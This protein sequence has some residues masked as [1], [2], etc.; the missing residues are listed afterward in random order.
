MTNEELDE[1]RM[2]ESMRRTLERG[3]SPHD[4][5]GFSEFAGRTAARL[6]R[7]GWLPTDPILNRA[8]DIVAK[9]FTDAGE[10]VSAEGARKGMFDD[11]PIMRA[12][13]AALQTAKGD[14][15]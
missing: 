1:A 15:T 7:E 11:Y 3:F 6:A 4:K 8:R 14:H 10:S 9:A 13:L 5:M 2:R 12:T